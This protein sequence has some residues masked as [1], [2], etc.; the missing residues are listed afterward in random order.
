MRLGLREKFLVP[1]MLSIVLG[2]S[3]VVYLSYQRSASAIEDAV[4]HS[5]EREVRLTVN[6]IDIWIE[7]RRTD[8]A[9]WSQDVVFREA[10]VETG[11]YGQSAREG[12]VDSL[13][14][15]QVGY[16]YY[17]ILF[18]ANPQGK[19]I[20]ASHPLRDEAINISDRRYFQAAMNGEIAVSRLLVSRDSGNPGFI[21]AAPVRD[22]GAVVGIFGGFVRLASFSAQFVDEFYLDGGYA[23]LVDHTGKVFAASRMADTRLTDLSHHDFGRRILNAQAGSLTYA[24]AGAQRIA[25][26]AQA[27]RLDWTFVETQSLDRALAATRSAGLHGA[28]AGLAVILVVVLVMALFFGRLISR[29]LT[30]MLAAIGRLESGDL[31]VRIQE[32]AVAD[33]VGVLTQAFNHMAER[34]QSTLDTLHAEV[35]V[36]R[37]A[38]QELATHRDHLEELVFERTAELTQ[39]NAELQ[40]TVAERERAEAQLL[41]A[42]EAAESANR[43]KSE[44]LANMSH[45]IRTPMTAIL[46]FSEVLLES[47]GT[48]DALSGQ[49]EAAETIQRN[50]EHLLSLI[51]DILDISKVEAGR[52]EIEQIAFS[53]GALVEEVASL[54]R[55]RATNKQLAFEVEYRGSLP[56]AIESDPT[57]LR[58]IL[59]NLVGNA[60]K[61]TDAGSVRLEV[62]A[63]GDTNNPALQFDVIDSGVGMTPEQIAGI[64]RPFTQADSSTTRRYGGTGLGLAISK[65][66]AQ[67]LDG[68]VTLVRSA[69]HG[70]SHFRLTVVAKVADDT[71]LTTPAPEQKSTAAT[72]ASAPE[73]EKPLGG[74]SLLLAEDGQDNQRLLRHICAKAGA[75][76]VVVENGKQAC[77][78]AQ[79]AAELGTPYDVILMDMQMPVMDGYSATRSLRSADYRGVIIALT[80]HAMAADRDRCLAAGC[81]DYVSKPIDRRQLIETIQRYA[82][83]PIPTS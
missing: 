67:I 60:I 2:M 78:A 50:G 6:Q 27:D 83:A 49:R 56:A 13:A 57:R 32:P 42:K 66:L 55:V 11:Y 47:A 16:P 12:A 40:R 28:A 20:A 14:M 45:E 7:A 1:V 59:I 51:N 17:E 75:E 10:I 53:P 52:M 76:L 44:F 82:G 38:E 18:L 33:E 68:D 77:D 54:M 25:S 34:L 46:G 69:P 39:S 43:A 26:F 30:A 74:C 19:L 65:R 21:F 73:Q 22:N 4:Q 64:F 37:R 79:A 48:N 35:A 61:F 81:D 8:L 29:R 5:L 41:V 72:D 58:Q 24:F 62:E 63:V 3:A 80:A 15:L 71:A 23:F 70:G 31:D 36:R 9:T